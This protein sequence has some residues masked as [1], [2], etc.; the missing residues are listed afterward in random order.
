MTDLGLNLPLYF[1]GGVQVA[2]SLLLLAPKPVSRLVAGLFRHTKST[3]VK[4]VLYTTAAILFARAA[5]S[6]Y[7]AYDI[8]GDIRTTSSQ[9]CGMHSRIC[10][11]LPAEARCPLQPWCPR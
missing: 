10:R 1:L 7:Q 5:A 2:I 11:L 6:A 3:V 4:T 9:R 8:A